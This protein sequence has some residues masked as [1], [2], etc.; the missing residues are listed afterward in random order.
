M[1]FAIVLIL[2]SHADIPLLHRFL[3]LH[4]QTSQQLFISVPS[5]SLCNVLLLLSFQ[6]CLHIYYEKWWH[7]LFKREFRDSHKCSVHHGYTV[8]AWKMNFLLIHQ[9]CL[10]FL[11]PCLVILAWTQ[12]F[13][14]MDPFVQTFQLVHRY[15]SSTVC[16]TP[17]C[18][19]KMFLHLITHFHGRA[20]WQS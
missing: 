14:S 17:S 10:T 1:L 3:F 6:K 9:R 12:H 16:V 18:Q 20:F 13:Q 15:T 7:R 2:W 5:S 19:I 8:L 4:T 11:P